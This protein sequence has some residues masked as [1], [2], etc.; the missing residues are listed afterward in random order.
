VQAYAVL[1][2]LTLAI[3]LVVWLPARRQPGDVAGAA[4]MGAGVAIYF[5]EFWR[6]WEGR[7]DVFH[8]M[9]D[10]PQ[11]AAIV[12]VISGALMLRS[13]QPFSAVVP[14]SSSEDPPAS[15]ASHG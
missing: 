11:V 9:L 1:S 7:G 3:L 12:F 4:L 8:G 10:G 5:T 13:R 6:D 2:F 14:V 15:E